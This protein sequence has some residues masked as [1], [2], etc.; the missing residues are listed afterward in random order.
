MEADFAYA[1]GYGEA[2]MSTIYRVPT[3]G[4][5]VTRM[6]TVPSSGGEA[7]IRSRSGDL[8]VGTQFSGNIWRIPMGT[9]TPE[10]FV[11]LPGSPVGVEQLAEDDRYLYVTSCALNQV[12]RFDRTTRAMAVLVEDTSG[13]PCLN[14]LVVTDTMIY[15]TRHFANDIWA[16][17]K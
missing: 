6:T 13:N 9:G 8:F 12:V 5:V 4:G 17:R 14:G 16:M 2:G 11:T 10:V 1:I 15:Y 7:I 3:T